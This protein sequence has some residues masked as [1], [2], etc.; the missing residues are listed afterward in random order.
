MSDAGE[1]RNVN[2]EGG[3]SSS[4]IS[5]NGAA[6]APKND[7]ATKA[8]L[9][10]AEKKKLLKA[11]KAARRAKDK[12]SK[13]PA[14]STTAT[15]QSS[16]NGAQPV[17]PSAPQQRKQK[18]QEQ[19]KPQSGQHRRKDSTVGSASTVQMPLRSKIA[20]TEGKKEKQVAFFAHLYGPPRQRGLE[21]APKEVHPAISAL[22]LHISSYVICGSHARAVAMLLALKSVSAGPTPLHN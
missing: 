11:E 6:T 2:G 4:H 9:T 14:V 15:A 1:P 13:G 5:T 7:D 19:K 12:E 21:G 17:P 16:T 20:E 18:P 10:N 22:A 3:S 8:E